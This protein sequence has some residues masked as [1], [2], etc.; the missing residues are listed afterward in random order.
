MTICRICGVIIV[1]WNISEWNLNISLYEINAASSLNLWPFTL[2]EHEV[3]DQY[4][5]LFY[6]L[7]LKNGERRNF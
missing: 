4:H 6:V 2:F 3:N 5:H 1:P 7:T